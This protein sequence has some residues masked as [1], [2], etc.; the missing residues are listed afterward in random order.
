MTREEWERWCYELNGNMHA[1]DIIEDLLRM[2]N[3]WQASDAAFIDR[4]DELLSDRLDLH[5]TIDRLVKE[6]AERD[7]REKELQ[8]EI[9]RLKNTTLMYQ[10]MTI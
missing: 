2:S 7:K 6:I 4:I 3:D 8:A 5:G 1:S 9:E 10:R